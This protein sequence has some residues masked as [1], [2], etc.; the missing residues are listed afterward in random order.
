MSQ[1]LSWDLNQGPL[2]YELVSL[3][4]GPHSLLYNDMPT[5]MYGFTVG[6]KV[7]NKYDL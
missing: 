2:G 5:D 7:Q 1:Q 4:T 6:R 3:T